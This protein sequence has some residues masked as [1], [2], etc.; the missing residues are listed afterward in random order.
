MTRTTPRRRTILHLSQI[1][2]MDALTFILLPTSC[3]LLLTSYLTLYTIRP[4][5]RS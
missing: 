5:V 2:L 1:L 3:F 4:R